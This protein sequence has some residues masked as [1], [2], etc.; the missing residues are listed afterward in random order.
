MKP[1]AAKDHR[2]NDCVGVALSTLTHIPYSQTPDFNRCP[3]Y[4]TQRR[5]AMRWLKGY[6]LALLSY[7]HSEGPSLR[8]FREE[9]WAEGQELPPRGYYVGIIVNGKHLW[10]GNGGCHAVVMKG[11]RVAYDPTYGNPDLDAWHLVALW[12]VY[13][14]DPSKVRKPRRQ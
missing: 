7:E 10:D 12:M 11:R 5:R 1:P 4:Q 8:Q 14:L 13:P 3:G 6:D 2:K 9:K